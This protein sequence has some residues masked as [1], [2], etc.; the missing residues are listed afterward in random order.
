MAVNKPNTKIKLCGLMTQEDVDY[1][2]EIKPDYAGFIMTDTFR[3]FV[4]PYE[5]S[6]FHYKLSRE[7]GIYV[8]GV[9]FDEPIEYP[10]EMLKSRIIDMVQLH[11]HE[12]TEYMHRIKDITGRGII[13]AFKIESEADIDEANAS[14]ADIVLLDSGTGTGKPF[15]HSLLSK[16]KRPYILAGGLTPENVEDAVNTLHPY[17]V[18]VSSGIETDGKKDPAKMKAFVEAVRRADK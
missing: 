12:D 18:D 4:P 2:C 11:G 15:D 17:G 6:D 3:R 1:V 9:F 8:I 10:L 7:N 16:M 13:K 14:P 5:V